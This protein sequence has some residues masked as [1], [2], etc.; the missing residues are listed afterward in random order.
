MSEARRAALSARA[1]QLGLPIVEDSPYRGLW[2]DAPP[3]PPLSARNPDGCLYL[4]SFS[5][6]LAPGLRLGFPVAPK[7]LYPKPLQARQ[8]ADLHSPGWINHENHTPVGAF[9][10]HGG[11]LQVRRVPSRAGHGPWLVAELRPSQLLWWALCVV[12]VRSGRA[13]GTRLVGH[14]VESGPACA[15]HTLRLAR[16]PVGL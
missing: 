15:C 10:I 11:R 1:A 7:A 5:K 14:R 3:P 4:G 8:A 6:V 12:G 9:K 2:I 13:I 16:S